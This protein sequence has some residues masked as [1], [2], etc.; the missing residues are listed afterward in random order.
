MRE[1]TQTR[2]WA[3]WSARIR[4]RYGR[5]IAYHVRRAR[6]WYP[7]VPEADLVQEVEAAI[8]MACRSWRAGRGDM[9]FSTYLH[10]HLA[11]RLA[12][13]QGVKPLSLADDADVASS[14]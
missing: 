4:A 2:G 14:A 10:W 6:R 9:Q 5:L 11:K 1:A 8:W 12:R 7:E 3:W 13:L